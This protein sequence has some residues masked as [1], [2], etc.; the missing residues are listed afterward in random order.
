MKAIICYYRHFGSRDIKIKNYKLF[1][2]T[3]QVG[4]MSHI[5]G[6]KSFNQWDLLL[7]VTFFHQNLYF[8]VKNTENILY[9]WVLQTV[10]QHLQLHFI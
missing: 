7:G 2:D 8:W 9:F 10:T 1:E 5:F 4:G 3:M 6:S